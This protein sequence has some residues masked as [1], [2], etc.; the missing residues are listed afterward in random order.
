VSTRLL[1]VFKPE[2]DESPHGYYRRLAQENR[3]FSWTSLAR[4]VG[5]SSAITHLYRSPQSIATVLGLDPTWV[6]DLSEKEKHQRILERFLRR[7]RDAVCPDCLK[8]SAH[9]R[10]H[11][12]HTYVTA[13]AKHGGT[14]VDT[15]DRCGESLSQRRPIIERCAC[16]RF[17]TDIAS[18]RALPGA[19]WLSAVLTSVPLKRQTFEPRIK[20]DA[21]LAFSHRVQTLCELHDPLRT[22]ARRNAAAPQT[23]RDALEFL[24]PLEELLADWP[25]SFHAH[26]LS[27]LEAAPS[28][29][30]TLNAAMGLWYTRL[31]R[32][33]LDEQGEPFL[34]ETLK[35]VAERYPAF[36]GPD[37]AA[38]TA[39]ATKVYSL[40]DAAQKLGIRRDALAVAIEAKQVTAVTRSFGSRRLMYQL[41]EAE[42]LRLESARQGWVDEKTAK[43]MLDVPDATIVNLKACGALAWDADWR[44]DICKSG[45][46]GR[47]SVLKLVDQV[48]KSVRLDEVADDTIALCELNSR[49]V[50]DKKALQEV[51]NALATG[52]LRGVGRLPSQGIGQIHFLRQDVARFFGTPLLEAG[53]TIERL[54][55]K[56]GWKYESVKHWIDEGLLKCSLIDLRGQDCVVLLPEH[57]VDFTR[58]YMPLTDM[59]KALDTTAS[60]VARRFKALPVVGAKPLPD[61]QRRGGLVRFRDLLHLALGEAD[62]LRNTGVDDMKQALR[63]VHAW[64]ATTGLSHEESL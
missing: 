10:V 54:C 33:S 59:A 22:K 19:L 57:L 37:G 35:V 24:R 60:A 31:K 15:C 53:L 45:P 27:R 5:G 9:L 62:Q 39:A 52:E 55:E 58:Q 30:R 28:P 34:T 56:T 17:L 12:Q 46:I 23:I 18:D 26:V 16:G 6:I 3:L 43:A 42:V 32:H 2:A 40:R 63:Q 44:S 36:L 4:A 7:G 64:S 13:C 50:G 51:F 49:R 25:A 41:Q 38:K 14:L 8:E 21:P 11:W 1:N 20:L 48:R 29:A 47:Q 61:G